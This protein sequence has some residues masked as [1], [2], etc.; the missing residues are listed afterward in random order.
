[1]TLPGTVELSA[2]VKCISYVR[3]CSQGSGTGG[4]SLPETHI[5]IYETETGFFG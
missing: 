4:G 3:Y 1:M 2:N 5:H